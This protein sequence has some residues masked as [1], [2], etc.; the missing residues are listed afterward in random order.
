MEDGTE[1]VQDTKQSPAAIEAKVTEVRWPAS[2]MPSLP[3]IQGH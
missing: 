1:A 3:V 2:S